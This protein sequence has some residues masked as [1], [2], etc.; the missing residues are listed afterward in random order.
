VS[1]IVKPGVGGGEE[2]GWVAEYMSRWRRQEGA[3]DQDIGYRRH[4]RGEGVKRG[5]GLG[6]ASWSAASGEAPCSAAQGQAGQRAGAQPAR[7]SG[8]HPRGRC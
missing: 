2:G 5:L 8:A 4:E 6:G 7:G 1:T 3:R